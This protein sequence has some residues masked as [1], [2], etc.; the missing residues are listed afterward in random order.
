MMNSSKNQKKLK[1]SHKN[2]TNEKSTQEIKLENLVLGG[3]NN[4][5]I[6]DGE[7]DNNEKTHSKPLSKR[8]SK[9]KPAW[10]DEDDNETDDTKEYMIP[11]KGKDRK[12]LQENKFSKISGTVSWAKIDLEKSEK[13]DESDDLLRIASTKIR[14]SRALPSGEIGISACNFLISGE[15]GHGA[16]SSVEFHK[17]KHM[18][19]TGFHKGKAVISQVDGT[20]NKAITTVDFDYK[21]NLLSIQ[22]SAD[23]QKIIASYKN[24]HLLLVHDLMVGKTSK[25]YLFNK[26]S[27]VNQQIRLVKICPDGNLYVAVCNYGYIHLISVKTNE[28][29]NTLKLNGN[30]N[31]VTFNAAGDLMY[32]ATDEGKVHIWNLKT[33]DCINQFIDD[34]S[35][36]GTCLALTSDYLACGSNSGVVN[37]YDVNNV[38]K[39]YEPQPL[40]AILN[41]TTSVTSLKFNST[42]EVLALSSVH[43]DNFIRLFH[44]PSLSVY[45]NFPQSGFN[46]YNVS[47]LD[48]SPS[49]GYFAVG[50]RKGLV[51]LYR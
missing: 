15:D 45:Q 2:S 13:K 1:K 51:S 16:V 39:T 25:I 50:T 20:E 37:L 17:E 38:V 11:V 22:W 35:I 48:F 40:K 26:S 7:D 3:V 24:L 19:V 8:H 9:R 46:H 34:G 30:V 4:T 18:T 14:K 43:K 28:V 12:S 41:L 49:S 31:D 44:V 5:W 29:I 36:R 33:R 32:C 47:C 23:G 21:R 27:Q 10:E 42:A 6:S